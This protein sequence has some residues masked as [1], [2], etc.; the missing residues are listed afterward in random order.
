[1]YCPYRPVTRGEMTVFVL[2]SRSLLA[3]DGHCCPPPDLCETNGP[4]FTDVP[5]TNPYVDFIEEMARM[6]I[7]SGC[8]AT[9]FCPSDTITRAEMAVYLAGTMLSLTD[10]LC[11]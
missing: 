6:C 5:C 8:S 4:I 1:M 11:A 9:T 7:L 3:Q 10:D 2:G